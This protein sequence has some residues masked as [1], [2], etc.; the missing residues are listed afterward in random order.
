MDIRNGLSFIPKISRKKASK[1]RTADRNSE[2]CVKKNR[3]ITG[4]TNNND[5][6]TKQNK[7]NKQARNA[8]EQP[9]EDEKKEK[10]NIMSRATN[11]LVG[12]LANWLARRPAG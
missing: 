10:Q 8:V 7:T 1:K 11:R 12:Q 3:S 5:K 2:V 6:R 9:M 4:K